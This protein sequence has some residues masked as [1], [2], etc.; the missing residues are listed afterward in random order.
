M[1]SNSE[2]RHTKNVAGVIAK[3]NSP[4]GNNSLHNR[5]LLGN[6]SWMPSS[7]SLPADEQK[8]INCWLK[9]GAPN[10]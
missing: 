9:A 6:P 7:G 3:A 10:N 2:I 5:T 1:T 8:K 4:M